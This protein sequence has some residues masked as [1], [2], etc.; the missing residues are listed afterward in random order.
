MTRREKTRKGIFIIV[1]VIFL[2]LI[3]QTAC[4][5]KNATS[6][7]VEREMEETKEY[8]PIQEIKE[9][10]AYRAIQK[11]EKPIP[12][13]NSL[14]D[15]VEKLEYIYQLRNMEMV[16]EWELGELGPLPVQGIIDV[17]FYTVEG[18]KILFLPK[19]KGNTKVL[20][21]DK[22]C[23]VYKS[24]E[25][26]GYL[27]YM[28]KEGNISE[29]GVPLSEAEN[30]GI[31]YCSVKKESE[32][33]DEE[34]T[35]QRPRH[36]YGEYFFKDLVWL[37]E[38]TVS[39][40][41][42]ESFHMPP[43][44]VEENEY[45]RVLLN[46]V[47]KRIKEEEQYGDYDVYINFINRAPERRDGEGTNCWVSFA[48]VG[49]KL[50]RNMLCIIHDNGDIEGLW[51]MGDDLFKESNSKGERLVDKAIKNARGFIHLEVTKETEIPMEEELTYGE[52][53][54]GRDYSKLS[55]EEALELIQYAWSYGEWFGMNE[56]GYKSGEVRGLGEKEVAVML[57]EYYDDRFYFRV[58][59]E[60]EEIYYRILR[61]KDR[62]QEGQLET[63]L[64][65][66][67]EKDRDMK[68]ELGRGKIK[69]KELFQLDIK[70]IKEDEYVVAMEGYIEDMLLKSGEKGE[71]EIYYGEYEALNK[72]KVCLSAGVI[73]EKEYYI[74]CLIVKYGEGKY[75]FW[76]VGFGLDGSLEE[77]EAERR[78]MN[79]V[80]IERTKQL[81]RY[82]QEIVIGG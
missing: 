55:L 78:H 59:G 71:Y 33:G 37:G 21:G 12:Y 1:N 32:K 64:I 3:I 18:N 72:N 47:V 57:S 50:R 28:I 74:R 56:L 2:A 70:N 58:I 77:C 23:E 13:N 5:R 26:G 10:E 60:E 8:E 46:D 67:W 4:A 66:R 19:G 43:I 38:A 75:Y 51:T 7:I 42:D 14:E 15:I 31:R 73:G 54:K 35:G 45:I 25:M 34:E 6:E 62:S 40:E 39:V 69:E 24:E 44:E 63:G 76:P 82:R 27:F 48:V 22:N 65:T 68:E 17:S 16:D 53:E 52:R 29:Y 30:G 79:K 49:E 20:V 61:S 36:F 11:K 80:C 9:T 41:V 81:K